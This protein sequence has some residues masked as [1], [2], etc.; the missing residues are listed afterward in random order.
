MESVLCKGTGTHNSLEKF[1]FSNTSQAK[2]RYVTAVNV[3]LSHMI[4]LID[5]LTFLGM[6][7]GSN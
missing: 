7:D 6:D 5:S 4:G 1:N 3:R 2:N